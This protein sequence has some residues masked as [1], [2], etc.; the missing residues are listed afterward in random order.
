[1]NQYEINIIKAREL[2]EQE[3]F[4]DASQ[5][6]L[7]AIKENP[8]NQQKAIVWAELS[9]LFYRQKEYQRCIEATQNTL[10]LDPDYKTKDDLYRLC[11]YSY[12]A[13]SQMDKATEFL[14]KSLQIDNAS[15]KQQ[16]AIFEL[17]KIYFQRQEYQKCEH[18]I[19]QV[20]NYLFQNQNDYWLTVLFFKGFVKYY[21]NEVEESEQIFEELLENSKD[22]PRK[23]TALFGLAFINYHRQNYL[24]TINLCESVTKHDPTFFDMES[25]GFLTAASFKNLER[26]DIFE[27]YY[28]ELK[29]KYPQGRYTEALDKMH[30]EGN[31]KD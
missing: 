21:L 25:V 24:N 8:D 19:S 2:F 9:W 26:N 29:K 20:E 31:G 5:A 10:E 28:I 17:L 27:K 1:M 23:A 13:L 15:E 7:N 6:Y 14:E 16:L 11:G 4:S 30:H 22:D 18:W 3:K 12:S